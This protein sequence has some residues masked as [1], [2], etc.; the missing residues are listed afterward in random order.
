MYKDDFYGFAQG[1]GISIPQFEAK[2]YDAVGA[3]PAGKVASYGQLAILAGCPGRARHAGAALKHAPQGLPCH[4]VVN[5][6]GRTA[7]G[8]AEQVVL[9]KKE[10]VSF[11]PSGRVNMRAHRWIP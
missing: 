9:L 7:P 3:I 11:L 4:R 2:V 6:S 8:W 5:S 10:G 1:A